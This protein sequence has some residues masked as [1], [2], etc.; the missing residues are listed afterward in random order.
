[1]HRN[2]Q[3]MVR[4][5]E[6]DYRDDIYYLAEL[7]VPPQRRILRSTRQLINIPRCA[8]KAPAS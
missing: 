5:E 8:Q 1:M 2:M 7:L 4:G 6:G 3:D